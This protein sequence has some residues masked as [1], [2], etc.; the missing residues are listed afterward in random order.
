MIRSHVM[1]VREAMLLLI[2]FHLSRTQL[3][4]KNV[5]LS[6]TQQHMKSVGDLY[7]SDRISVIGDWVYLKLHSIGSCI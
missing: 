1:D 7:I 4:M 3:H 5:G 2:K 6:R